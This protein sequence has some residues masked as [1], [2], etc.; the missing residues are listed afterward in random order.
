MLYRRALL[1]DAKG[2]VAELE[3]TMKASAEAHEAEVLLD[4]QP[5][6]PI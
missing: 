2:T 1:D 6:V 4:A 3:E 5:R